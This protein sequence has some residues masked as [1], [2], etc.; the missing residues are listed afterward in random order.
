MNKY[1]IVYKTCRTESNLLKYMQFKFCR[2]KSKRVE[3]KII[4]ENIMVDSFVELMKYTNTQIR[5]AQQTQN[6]INT[7]TITHVHSTST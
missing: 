3:K 2:E 5:K 1:I 6:S 7:H 4:C